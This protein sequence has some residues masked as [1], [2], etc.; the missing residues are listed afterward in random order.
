M[1]VAVVDS[2]KGFGVLAPCL[3][4]SVGKTV[5]LPPSTTICNG[6][7][8]LQMLR[9]PEF[10]SLMTVPTI[11]EDIVLM[12]PSGAAALKLARLDFVV[13]GGGGIKDSVGSALHTNGVTLLNHFGATELGALAPIFRPDKSYDWRY[14]RLRKDMGL[15]LKK[16]ESKDGS[17]EAHMLIGH[18][19]GSNSMFELQDSLEVN[20]LKPEAEVKILGRKDDLLVLATGEKVSPSTM[21]NVMEQEPSIKRAIV[22]GTGQFEVGVLI[23]PVPDVTGRESAFIDA[24]W[25]AIIEANKTVDQHACISSKAAVVVKPPDKQIPLSDKGS[26]QR[27]E[28]YSQF[29]S[30]IQ[31]MYDRLEKEGSST[32]LQPIDPEDPGISVRAIVQMCLPPHNKPGLWT[33]DD[34]FVRLGMDSVR[35]VPSGSL[36][37]VSVLQVS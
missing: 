8:V 32:A 31:S 16:L 19:F 17:D 33:D 24:I 2:R 26:A 6:S 34:D 12:E 5:C 4:L 28:V 25:P 13:V 14:L 21:E 9:N 18:Q 36:Q 7:L 27:K 10:T 23:E 22:F 30:E 35:T 1:L 29:D 20:P 37:N 15:K 11:L 3:A